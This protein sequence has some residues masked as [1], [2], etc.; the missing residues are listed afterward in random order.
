MDARIPD[1]VI[2]AFRNFLFRMPKE[3]PA[4]EQ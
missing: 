1:D 2:N 4:K 3:S